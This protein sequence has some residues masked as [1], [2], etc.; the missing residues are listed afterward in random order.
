VTDPVLIHPHFDLTVQVWRGSEQGQLGTGYLVG[1][2]IVITALHC[3]VEDVVAAGAGCH[4]R[5]FADRPRPGKPD[6]KFVPATLIWPPVGSLVDDCDIAVLAVAP[7]DRTPA[8]QQAVSVR[9]HIPERPQVVEGV[10]FPGWRKDDTIGQ[11]EPHRAKGTLESNVS[12]MGSLHVFEVEGATPEKVEDWHGLSGAVLFARDTNVALGLASARNKSKNNNMLGVTLLRKVA[13]D[14]KFWTLSGLPKP[15]DKDAALRQGAIR[16]K[17]GRVMPSAFL[18]LFDRT[19]QHSRVKLVV[20]REL[21]AAPHPTVIVPIIGRSEDEA[22]YL[23]KRLE[24]VLE[25]QFP[26]RRGTYRNSEIIPWLQD[27]ASVSDIA[28]EMLFALKDHLHLAGPF[29]PLVDTDPVRKAI[30][31]GTVSRSFRIE[32]SLA[33]DP[34]HMEALLKIVFE[35]F[36]AFGGHDSPLALFLSIDRDKLPDAAQKEPHKNLPLTS[37]AAAA[38]VHDKLLKWLPLPPLD[39]CRRT[40]FDRWAEEL[41]ALNHPALELDRLVSF[42]LLSAIHTSEQDFDK[43]FSFAKARFALEKLRL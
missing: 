15:T 17:P 7:A 28:D 6:W 25:A 23:I 9:S 41:K 33:D 21:T 43:P 26:N 8:M 31:G 29:K 22:S 27:G 35:R 36:A 32:A 34:A 3:V 30:E 40:D 20:D 38:A 18:H 16:A 37:L 11:Y 14:E 10:G 13:A 2:G 1:P 24:S 19:P 39:Q 4:V 42:D 5:L 12:Y